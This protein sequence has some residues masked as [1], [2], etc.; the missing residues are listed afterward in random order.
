MKAL[1]YP[2]EKETSTLQ[3]IRHTTTVG[4]LIDFLKGYDEDLPIV[5]SFD[6]GYT[7]GSIDE[8]RIQEWDDAED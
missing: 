1:I 8:F 7:Y 6:G 3:E 5:L 4:A 2:A